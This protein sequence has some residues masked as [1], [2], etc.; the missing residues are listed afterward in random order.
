[1][2]PSLPIT[3]NVL[4]LL[5]SGWVWIVSGRASSDLGFF[6]ALAS[7]VE[8]QPIILFSLWMKCLIVSSIANMIYSNQRIRIIL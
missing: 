3:G 7:V 4:D 5:P 1:M 8:I 2:I 6:V